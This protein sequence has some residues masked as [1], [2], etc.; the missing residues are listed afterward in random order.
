MT[1]ASTGQLVCGLAEWWPCTVWVLEWC[2]VTVDNL[3]ANQLS[4]CGPTA[5][6]APSHNC[7]KEGLMAY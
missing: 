3:T 5:R 6:R 7:M 2:Q 1:T 4:V